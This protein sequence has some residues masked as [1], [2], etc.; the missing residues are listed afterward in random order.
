M[1]KYL[2]FSI[3]IISKKLALYFL[4]IV[5]LFFSIFFALD[6]INYLSN[7]LYT[8]YFCYPL[9]TEPFIC[10]MPINNI[11]YSSQPEANIL[12]DT[13][14]FDYSQLIRLESISQCCSFAA[15]DQNGNNY[16]IR[17]YSS[18]ITEKLNIN[19]KKSSTYKTDGEPTC[20]TSS[21]QVNIGDNLIL[22]LPDGK[23]S[24][25]TK[26]TGIASEPYF[27][28][29]NTCMSAQCSF[30]D[31]FKFTSRE[32]LIFSNYEIIWIDYESIEEFINQYKLDTT[33]TSLAY[34]EFLFF[35][36][37]VTET[38]MK[39]NEQ[40][41]KKNSYIFTN[42]TAFDKEKTNYYLKT[43]LT[44]ALCTIIISLLGALS[45][46]A[47]CIS[48]SRRHF[49]ILKMCGAGKKHIQ[50]IIITIVLMLLMVSNIPILLVNALSVFSNMFDWNIAFIKTNI[51]YAFS[52]SSI[53]FVSFILIS[54][55]I[56]RVWYNGVQK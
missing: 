17:A 33:K 14:D 49:E 10:N 52:L 25:N 37:N 38:D 18:N 44:P 11:V 4:I 8:E 24:F 2:Y 46:F 48:S 41:L 36:P 27:Y 40:L 16:E 35:E 23:A 39:T 29:D 56:I 50:K 9:T 6:S 51:V 26:V 21:S 32:E 43:E 53:V 7:S 30:S 28:I 5:Q 19:I 13:I 15:Y 55:C 12:P 31:V 3:D 1:S 22:T 34:N 54:F 20:F 45:S 47:I 42:N